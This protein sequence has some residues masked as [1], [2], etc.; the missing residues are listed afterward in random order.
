M[1]QTNLRNIEFYR[2]NG[3][4]AIYLSGCAL[5]G[6]CPRLTGGEN[7]QELFQ[8]CK[9]HNI[10]AIVAMALETAWKVSPPDDPSVMTPWLQARDMAVRKNILL[11]AEREQILAHLEQIGCWYLPL[12][13][14]LLQ[15]DYPRFGMRQMGDNDI[16]VDDVFLEQ[17][18]E[19]MCARGYEAVHYRVGNHDEYR[20]Q[21][22]YNIE[23]H[24]GLFMNSQN[25]I[26]SAYYKDIAGRMIK[27]D[28]NR[29]GYHLSVNDFYIYLIAHAHKHYLHGGIG[30]RNLMD[31]YVYVSKHGAQM[32]WDYIF[33]ELQKLDAVSFEAECRTLGDKVYSQPCV[34]MLLS[35]QEMNGLEIYLSSGT[36]GTVNRAVENKLRMLERRDGKCLIKWRYLMQRLFPTV[37]YMID[38]DP[39]LAKKRWL[40]PLAYLR[41]LLRGA[42]ARRKASLNELKQLEAANKDPND[43]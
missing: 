14:S 7:L 21:P 33:R 30:I 24:H 15:F 8:F 34:D 25:P 5:K 41:R 3:A 31:V 12:K 18:H 22:V 6:D 35:E 32:D 40:I 38:M 39:E 26:H 43:Q 23:I 17:I 9:F 29:Y 10:T 1:D 37:Q 19:Y 2:N 36:F 27:D 13:G 28:H 20:K 42:F 11:N 4:L 16:L